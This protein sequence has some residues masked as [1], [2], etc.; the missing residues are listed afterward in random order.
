MPNEQLIT[1]IRGELTRGIDTASLVQSLLATGWKIEDI[2]TAMATVAPSSN[3]GIPAPLHAPTAPIHPIYS[4]NPHPSSQLV[5]L[6]KA[7]Q[8]IAAGL[9][10]ACVALLTAVSVL[11]VWELFDG[12]VI[13]K[14]FA[15]LGLL[16]LVAMI[17]IG[18]GKFVGDPSVVLEPVPRPG[19]RATR[20]ITLTSLIVSS[21]LLALLG[22]LSIWDVITDTKIIH[23]SLTT[24]GIIAFSSLIIV[25]VCLEREQN[26]FWRK[27]AKGKF[28][29]GSII[30]FIILGWLVLSLGRFF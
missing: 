19:Y 17:V 25:M 18:A 15:T 20:N 12:D 11:G 9:F 27:Y 5:S 28:S 3:Q 2:N 26:Q 6:V 13:E 29:G 1:Y 4:T 8:D 21:S 23:K 14:S 7:V 10:I 24:L 22:V 30:G 16:A